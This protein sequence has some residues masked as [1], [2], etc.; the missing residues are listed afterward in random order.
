MHRFTGKNQLASKD[1][2]GIE[3]PIRRFDK[4]NVIAEVR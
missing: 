2:K 4:I 1:L 3:E